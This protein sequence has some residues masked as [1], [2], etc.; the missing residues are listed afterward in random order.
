MLVLSFSIFIFAQI[1]CLFIYSSHSK[2]TAQKIG[3]IID[4]NSRVILIEQIDDGIVPY[5]ENSG[6]EIYSYISSLPAINCIIYTDDYPLFKAYMSENYISQNWLNKSLSS[7]KNNY[8]LLP[9]H[10]S[11]NQLTLDSK[12]LKFIKHLDFGRSQ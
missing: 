2:D 11:T 9:Q 5:L 1:N 8:I 10:I 6:I 4:K 12:N 3:E 7:T